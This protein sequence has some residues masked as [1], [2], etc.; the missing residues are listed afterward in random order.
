MGGF[1]TSQGFVFD[2]D[3]LTEDRS[4]VKTIKRKINWL[5]QTSPNLY[6]CL[7]WA[8]L[9]FV[10]SQWLLSENKKRGSLFFPIG[11]LLPYHFLLDLTSRHLPVSNYNSVSGR[12]HPPQQHHIPAMNHS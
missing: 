10:V 9:L 7:N 6:D 12:D 4:L 11:P 5:T 3:P 2:M 8:L 1:G